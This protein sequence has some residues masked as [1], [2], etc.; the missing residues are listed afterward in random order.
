VWY[1]L[2]DQEGDGMKLAD[3]GT[4]CEACKPFW[5]AQKLDPKLLVQVFHAD[6]RPMLTEKKQIP[7]VVCP[8]CDGDL[9]LKL[10]KDHEHNDSRDDTSKS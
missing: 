1:K 7:I 2:S 8:Y 4:T 6:G 10:K 5:T 9:I 3:S